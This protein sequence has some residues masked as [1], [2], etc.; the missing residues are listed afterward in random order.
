M[1]YFAD[2]PVW[3]RDNRSQSKKAMTMGDSDGSPALIY[4]ELQSTCS[5]ALSWC[6]SYTKNSHAMTQ[7]RK[8]IKVE[9][10]IVG[11]IIPLPC[12][13]CMCEDQYPALTGTLRNCDHS[14][15][16]QERA[17]HI[18]SHRI[19]SHRIITSRCIQ[20]ASFYCQSCEKQLRCQVYWRSLCQL[21]KRLT[22]KMM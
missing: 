22:H 15:C 17:H 4:F 6:G 8:E 2:N 14:G 21:D 19:I 18:T 1:K 20:S 16:S 12:Y 11:V 13:K 10:A 7:G 5:D 9:N 3:S